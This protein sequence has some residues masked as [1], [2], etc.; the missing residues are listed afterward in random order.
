LLID[1]IVIINILDWIPAKC[2]AGKE[3]KKKKEKVMNT[4][5]TVG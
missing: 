3:K 1:V 4:N 2:G 5:I